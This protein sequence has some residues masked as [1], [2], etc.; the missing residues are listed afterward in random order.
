MVI[1]N[2]ARVVV[3]RARGTR[4]RNNNQSNTNTESNRLQEI[5]S[6]KEFMHRQNVQRQYRGFLRAVNCIQDI[7]YRTQGK[8]EVRREFAA[9]KLETDSLAVSMAV[10]EGD[11]KLKELRSIVGQKE[12][13][14]DDDSWLNIQDE[15]DPRGRVGVSWPWEQTK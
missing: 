8:E 13:E 11:R 12:Q 2:G 7:S 4:N 6:M 14:Q 3:N 5:P 9:R 1:R 15:E 10:K